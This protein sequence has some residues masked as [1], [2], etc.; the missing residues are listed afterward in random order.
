MEKTNKYYSI[1]ENIVKHHSKFPG[2]EALLDAIIDDVYAHSEVIINSINNE[3]VINAYLEKVVS[4]SMITVPKKNNIKPARKTSEFDI[5]A[6]KQVDYTPAD[7]TLV[8]RMINSNTVDSSVSTIQAASQKDFNEI[9]E[10]NTQAVMP[11][12]EQNSIADV[13]DIEDITLEEEP[14]QDEVQNLTTDDDTLDIND[15][16]FEEETV[17]IQNEEQNLTADNDTLDIEDISLEEDTVAIPDEVQNHTT[18][19]DTLDIE[20]I[21]LEEDT[22]VTQDEEQNLTTDDDTL[23]IED[24]PL[25]DTVVT[26]DEEQNLTT[27]DD[28]LNIEDIPLEE[29]TVVT[30]DEDQNLTT[31]DYDTLDIENITLEEESVAI[32]DEVEDIT[33]NDV[34]SNIEDISLEE[35]P[36]NI[37]ENQDLIAE[38]EKTDLQNVSQEE[39][40]FEIQDDVQPLQEVSLQEGDGLDISEDLALND[41]LDSEDLLEN[42]LE[43]DSISIE[44]EP[45]SEELILEDDTEDFQNNLD[46][47]ESN[48]VDLDI[49]TSEKQ[50]AEISGKS[51][52]SMFHYQPDTNTDDIDADEIIKEI[53]D[54]NQKRPD[55]NIIN[56]Y[57]LKYKNKLP[58]SDIAT[59]LD[60]SNDNVVEALNEII[61][62][63]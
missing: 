57:N 26:Q 33:T 48:I 39:A 43:E 23:N 13:F 51:D 37:E 12:E 41:S 61:S 14:S 22:V 53:L 46:I 7:K 59:Q 6:I 31:N 8:D 18:D 29:D 3:N 20:D 10:N 47:D 28:T 30:Q 17:A 11:K 62:I 9:S 56:V 55:L 36:V 49:D 38:D 19:D 21:P 45:A 25:E 27:D 35:E 4:T 54:L 50:T 24:I 52:F 5:T 32:Q 1:I 44:L 42:V 58:V 2:N 34:A 63:V 40:P 60:M 16:P 15:I